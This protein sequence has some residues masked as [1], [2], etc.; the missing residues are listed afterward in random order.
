MRTPPRQASRRLVAWLA[1]DQIRVG[2]RAFWPGLLLGV[3]GVHQ[4]HR[5]SLRCTA[6]SKP[7]SNSLILGL[8]LLAPLISPSPR[9]RAQ[10]ASS[11]SI[12][13]IPKG[14]LCLWQVQV[15]PAPRSVWL[16]PRP[17]TPLTI[18]CAPQG[19][20]RLSLNGSRRSRAPRPPSFR[21]L[22]HR[23]RRFAC[24]FS[25]P[26]SDLWVCCLGRLVSRQ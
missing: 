11:I 4:L 16:G 2:D 9:L 8:I 12:L 14:R 7:T 22:S 1:H 10:E 18:A 13:S 15:R 17:A 24:T 5:K 21:E 26:C 20:A 3:R 19:R 25:L 6:L 23:V